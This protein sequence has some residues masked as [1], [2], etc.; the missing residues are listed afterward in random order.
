MIAKKSKKAPTAPASG[1]RA[2]LGGYVNQT[3]FQIE[4]VIQCLLQDGSFESAEFTN[5]EAGNWDDLILNFKNE[6]IHY[7]FKRRRSGKIT[8]ST[9]CGSSA[10]LNEFAQSWLR[11]KSN[12]I[13]AKKT[14]RLEFVTTNPLSDNVSAR[15]PFDKRTTPPTKLSFEGFYL[16]ALLPYKKALCGRKKHPEKIIPRP[17]VKAFEIWRKSTGLT[18]GQ[19]RSFQSSFS[20]NSGTSPNLAEIDSQDVDFLFRHFLTI[21]ADARSKQ[22]VITVTAKE[23]IKLLN[24]QRFYLRNSHEFSLPREYQRIEK[25]SSVL[26]QKFLSCNTGYIALWGNPGSG[27]STLL[28][29]LAKNM[30]KDIRFVLYYAYLAEDKKPIVVPRGSI[31]NF[32][33]D[34]TKLID[35]AL[36]QL[37]LPPK[38]EINALRD[39]FNRQLELLHTDY[40][41]SKKK[42]IIIIDGLDHIERPDSPQ[43]SDSFLGYLPE[44]S[45]IP[46]GVV[47]ALGSQYLN[48][49]HLKSSI[50]S[51]IEANGEDRLVKMN[52]LNIAET[53][54]ILH[55]A[56]L[57][58]WLKK[59]KH[60]EYNER[61][62]NIHDL[63]EGHPLSTAYFIQWVK[64]IPAW[65][66]LSADGLIKKLQ[67]RPQIISPDYSGLWKEIEKKHVGFKDFVGLIARLEGDIDFEWIE[68][69][70]DYREEMI[71]FQDSFGHY[72]KKSIKGNWKFF[73]SSFRLFLIEKSTEGIS[74]QSQTRETMF[75]EKLVQKCL[76][77]AKR[78]NYRWNVIYHLAK[79][80]RINEVFK[81]ATLDFFL[82]Q[83]L[84]YRPISDISRDIYFC[85]KEAT[86][87]ERPDLI[88]RYLVL[89][90]RFMQAGITWD[91][92]NFEIQINNIL[93]KINLKENS[94]HRISSEYEGFKNTKKYRQ[95]P[96]LENA[97][98]QI[99]TLYSIGENLKA[100]ELF[101]SFNLNEVI[102]D[103]F[104]KLE[105]RGSYSEEN[106]TDFLVSWSFC[107]SYF[108]ELDQIMKYV[109]SLSWTSKNNPGV[110]LI[111]IT[112]NI[113]LHILKKLAKRFIYSKQFEK[114]E[115]IISEIEE[116]TDELKNGVSFWWVDLWLLALRSCSEDPK[117]KKKYI[118]RLINRFSIER[119]KKY[120]YKTK[121][122]KKTKEART[123][124][125]RQILE[126][127]PRLG[128]AHP[129]LVKQFASLISYEEF[130]NFSKE[131]L[132]K[133]VSIKID[134]KIERVEAYVFGE[135]LCGRWNER[136]MEKMLADLKSNTKY[137][138]E[139]R[140]HA[141]R[142]R[143]KSRFMVI[144]I[145]S[146]TTLEKS[147]QQKL[148]LQYCD[149]I[150]TY[151]YEAHVSRKWEFIHINNIG[152]QKRNYL[153]LINNLA[154]AGNDHLKKLVT[155]IDDIWNRRNINV[156]Y[157]I[158]VSV[159]EK[160]KTYSIDQ[161][162]LQRETDKLISQAIE[163]KDGNLG[164]IE[165]LM[166]QA[167]IAADIGRVEIAQALLKKSLLVAFSVRSEKDYQ[168]SSLMSWL[169][170]QVQ[171]SSSDKEVLEQLEE[172]AQQIYLN[173][174]EG[175]GTS[176][177]LI[178]FFIA[179]AEWC[180]KIAIQL[181]SEYV[182]KHL[183]SNY[184][185]EIFCGFIDH[186]GNNHLSQTRSPL[187]DELLSVLTSFFIVYCL[188]V[189]HDGPS[190]HAIRAAR[191]IVLL[192]PTTGFFSKAI[193]ANKLLS[194][195]RQLF[196]ISTGQKKFIHSVLSAIPLE[197]R[198]EVNVLPEEI[199]TLDD[200][201]LKDGTDQPYS[202]R[203]SGKD[204]HREEVVEIILNDPTAA[205]KLA[206][207]EIKT[208]E[209]QSYRRF[210][211][212]EVIDRVEFLLSEKE[213]NQFLEALIGGGCDHKKLLGFML[214]LES[215]GSLKD[216]SL[217][218]KIAEQIISAEEEAFRGWVK[219]IDGEHK[220]LA[221]TLLKRINWKKWKN[222]IFK[223]FLNALEG[224]LY[225]QGLIN[226]SL[227]I[228]GLFS[229]VNES[230]HVQAGVVRNDRKLIYVGLAD[231][232]SLPLNLSVSDDVKK[233]PFF[234]AAVHFLIDQ[235]KLPVNYL[236]KQSMIELAYLCKSFGRRVYRIVGER[237]KTE[238]CWLI[239]DRLLLLLEK[240]IENCKTLK[241]ELIP[242]INECAKLENYTIVA[243]A[244]KLLKEFGEAVPKKPSIV[245]KP[246]L[247][248][249][250]PEK[251]IIQLEA[252]S[253]LESYKN[254]RYGINPIFNYELAILANVLNVSREEVRERIAFFISKIEEEY[255]FKEYDWVRSSYI[256]SSALKTREAI[257]RY[258]HYI[259]IG[260]WDNYELPE[261][262]D[263]VFRG[264]DSKTAFLSPSPK[265]SW[266]K[267]VTVWP[268]HSH[269]HE[270][271]IEWA[272]SLSAK[273]ITER[274]PDKVEKEWIV[275]FE[276][277][278]FEFGG[279]YKN[280]ETRVLNFI[281]SGNP[282]EKKHNKDN[283]SCARL[284]GCNY[285]SYR[286]GNHEE[287]ANTL[288]V[289][290][291]NFRLLNA[292]PMWYGLNPKIATELGWNCDESFPPMWK[293]SKGELVCYSIAWQNGHWI[294]RH[295]SRKD[296]C[297]E[298]WG[299][300]IEINHLRELIAHMNKK[301]VAK[302]HYYEAV[303]ERKV[304]NIPI[305][306]FEPIYNQR[307]K[308]SR[309]VSL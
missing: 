81:T 214:R 196:P 234:E 273:Y 114:Y 163:I 203:T 287:D 19:F 236:Y 82:E 129:I 208:K 283:E 246:S 32:L 256:R 276:K 179:T 90:H 266:I 172:A 73:H 110:K 96:D 151:T 26:L 95:L 260:N 306:Q 59:G 58:Q 132:C 192:S 255:S 297:S 269:S 286:N 225:Y 296:A 1:E 106:K 66:K 27:K 117:R 211:W 86:K 184:L 215:R 212:S 108:Y 77:A 200:P 188:P 127:V 263:V 158:R 207:E 235:F 186:I 154:V 285:D 35:K 239:L 206:R 191:T 3:N 250:P 171:S 281:V 244:R 97:L 34:I 142:Q 6:T 68:T 72:F 166:Q 84:C 198:K 291:D 65:Q 53:E 249:I 125:V 289:R 284:I 280:T 105:D 78:F 272:N 21:V 262:A 258:V 70:D 14:L 87:V 252:D 116:C 279:D 189:H 92:S 111:K 39:K 49:K 94:T 103:E 268:E 131:D 115:T 55:Q 241:E 91:L 270:Q 183:Y 4:L 9:F 50:V 99:N 168:L 223:E 60:Y 100:A 22:K 149:H 247:L 28:T 120:F 30:A 229:N 119:L 25:T 213:N 137:W 104:L 301:S 304:F 307:K 43:I 222:R 219:Y 54:Q 36:G 185:D 230:Q 242:G 259:Q 69:W 261:W 300:L 29:D 202:L 122:Y 210:D 2:A 44:P 282:S 277:S 227:E 31:I 164:V 46:D 224:R 41:K 169:P 48:L 217:A 12:V 138:D 134:E 16:E 93:P 102:D 10:L 79:S 245:N 271:A 294:H 15:I 150:L 80:G 199:S 5:L 76:N 177:S 47:I 74:G 295:Y 205:E 145:T 231:R 180:P 264:H 221:L 251:K 133:D 136:R 148:M 40:L 176:D 237:L 57:A 162:W 17:W 305:S 220:L 228:N 174:Q 181:L 232:N 299:V 135:V 75:H 89:R 52:V 155:L 128:T 254:E 143:I 182:I 302:P 24:E 51:Y 157:D 64:D 233:V 140:W 267:E 292:Y 209:E 83:Y 18:L 161:E 147:E 152:V 124:A 173:H 165:Q 187:Q 126:L 190:R 170:L 197:K 216:R 298:G 278:E 141:I 309:K 33:N 288:I 101:E 201:A 85:T 113:Y 218:E 193:I 178:E 11:I 275:I 67:K 195:S 248:I 7:Q 257:N 293:N 71:L 107:A 45:S 63:T 156:P 194:I 204:Y 118:K 13:N 121:K 274:I 8:F 37:V 226:V 88:L 160:L 38:N 159:I 62:Q 56:E 146:W 23:L 144:E 42:T 308:T 253:A 130:I 238:T 265:P 303:F 20:V 240:E 139:D 123:T 290:V 112:K 98:G 243:T 175:E 109:K 153:Q 61:L 167:K